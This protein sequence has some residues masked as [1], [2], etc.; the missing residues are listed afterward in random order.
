MGTLLGMLSKFSLYKPTIEE[1]ACISCYRCSIVCKAN[2]ID[3]ESKSIDSSR[4]ILCFNCMV[5]CPKGGIGLSSSLLKGGSKSSKR[6]LSLERRRVLL[7]LGA[8]G[9]AIATN[10]ALKRP[11]L[12]STPGKSGI[13][14]PGAISVNHL[15]L[16]C[17]A[18]HACVAA[19]PATIIK[20]SLGEYGFDAPFLPLLNFDNHYCSFECTRCSEVC[21]NGALLPLTKEKK[22]ITA[23]AKAK[24]SLR[25][26]IV[27]TD[28]TDCGACEEHCPTKAINMVSYKG[29][30]L[31]IPHINKKECIGCG[32]CQYICPATPI[33]AMKVVALQEHQEITPRKE[34]KEEK[35]EIESFGF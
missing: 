34:Q 6:E 21:P 8:A 16:N 10:F 31:M 3:I 22:Q 19:C 18:C 4:C 1:E 25:E 9:G 11:L 33:K 12:A 32:A 20:P 2:C 26:C 27:Y 15:K 5:S 35:K 23:I 17:T 24:F 14:P 28:K 30:A 7:G 13:A 29:T